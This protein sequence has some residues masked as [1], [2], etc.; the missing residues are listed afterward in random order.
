MRNFFQTPPSP[1]EAGATSLGLFR[2]AAIFSCPKALTAS[3]GSAPQ[4]GRVTRGDK[5]AT[6]SR[7]RPQGCLARLCRVS[8][9][10]CAVGSFHIAPS[11]VPF[12]CAYGSFRPLC[13]RHGRGGECWAAIPLPGSLTFRVPYFFLVSW[14]GLRDYGKKGEMLQL[15][16][17]YEE[18]HRKRGRNLPKGAGETSQKTRAKPPKRRG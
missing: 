10:G 11:T 15:S 9:T 3:F 2:L 14:E 8:P 16:N 13:G 5:L 4:F 6:S 12:P 7:S 18:R 1:G 17:L